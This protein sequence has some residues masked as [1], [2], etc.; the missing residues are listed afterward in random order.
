MNT[1]NQFEPL[2]IVGLA[3]KFPQDAEDEEKFWRMLVEGRCAMTEVPADR[4]DI[5]SVYN[6]DHD[7]LDTV[8]ATCSGVLRISKLT[9]M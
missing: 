5:N 3:C 7:R 6:S 1:M 2:V 9:R 8:S 4:F